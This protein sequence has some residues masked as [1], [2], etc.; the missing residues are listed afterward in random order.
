MF[1]EV[2]GSR[3]RQRITRLMQV[4]PQRH[5]VWQFRI[6]TWNT[7]AGTLA[8][9]TLATVTAA[10]AGAAPL[11]AGA[12]TVGGAAAA[13]GVGRRYSNPAIYGRAGRDLCQISRLSTY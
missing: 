5:P 9:G 8:A 12:A 7:L 1:M 13:G 2:V 6:I 4:N 10:V 3:Q 11:A